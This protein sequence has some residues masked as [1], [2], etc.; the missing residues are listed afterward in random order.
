MS[1]PYFAYSQT[2]IPKFRE[3]RTL[4][5]KQTMFASVGTGMD[6]IHVVVFTEKCKP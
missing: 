6:D 4:Y 3:V 2:K 5:Q 1:G